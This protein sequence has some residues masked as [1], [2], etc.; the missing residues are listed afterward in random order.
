MSVW[1]H[2]CVFCTLAYFALWF[3]IWFILYFG[4]FIFCWK[5]SSFSYGAH[6]VDSWYST[7]PSPSLCVLETTIWALGVR[8]AVSFRASP[9]TKQGKICAYT[10]LNIYTSGQLFPDESIFI[11]MKLNMNSY[12]GLPHWSHEYIDRPSLLTPLPVCNLPL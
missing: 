8:V 3:V 5:F 4:L 10:N 11:C 2:G 12:W 6:S 7:S 9:R 1:T